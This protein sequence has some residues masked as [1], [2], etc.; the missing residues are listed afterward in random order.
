MLGARRHALSTERDVCPSSRGTKKSNS[1]YPTSLQHN[2]FQQ[3]KDDEWHL[4]CHEVENHDK[5]FRS[6]VS[7]L[8][9][10]DSTDGGEA[11]REPSQA[12]SSK[13]ID[14]IYSQG[15]KD[16][17]K[18]VSR[19]SSFC[20]LFARKSSSSSVLQY[21]VWL[22]FFNLTCL[23]RE[24]SCLYVTN[25]VCWM[26]FSHSFLLAAHWNVQWAIQGGLP[27]VAPSVL[28]LLA[29]LVLPTLN[30][31]THQSKHCRSH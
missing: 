27:K 10:G 6:I 11:T 18:S 8:P 31:H 16:H 26:V 24:N 19:G 3:E 14:A 21:V 13:E 2:A 7:G 22:N 23:L 20:I 29:A 1:L 17:K 5:D 9:S 4:W 30:T 15:L 25:H 28:S 12:F